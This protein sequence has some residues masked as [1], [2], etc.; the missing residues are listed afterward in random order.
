MKNL[1]EES[2]GKKIKRLREEVA[3]EQEVVARVLNVPRTAISA[4][5]LGKRDVASMEIIN[6]CKLFRVTPNDLL[7]WSKYK[8]RIKKTKTSE[9]E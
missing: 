5:E 7:G 2:L 4:I 9:G 3:M 6:L 8:M 1:T